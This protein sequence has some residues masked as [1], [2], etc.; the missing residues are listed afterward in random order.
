MF[1]MR[2]VYLRRRAFVNMNTRTSAIAVSFGIVAIAS[3]T[4]CTAPVPLTPNPSPTENVALPEPAPSLT[5]TP[6]AE[7]SML[8]ARAIATAS[9]GSQLSLEGHVRRSLSYDWPG[10]QTI[11][12]IMIDDCGDTLTNAIL[13]ADRWSFTMMNISAIPPEGSSEVWP[14]DSRID[15]RPSADNVYMAG[16]LFVQSD[17]A[18]GDLLCTQN[19]YFVEAGRGNIAV[20]LPADT[21]DQ[22]TFNNGWAAQTW[23]FTAAAGVTLS[24]CSFEILPLANDNGA[25]TA[26]WVQVA[27]ANN[28]YIGPPTEASVF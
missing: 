10:S 23:G 27:D 3:L 7:D 13:A 5:R 28:C 4:G 18:T 25:S 15:F 19:K 26:G 24:E 22:N 16:R 12:T 8:W 14:D 11:N 20:G 1:R 21:I 2:T 17:A 9:N 6:P